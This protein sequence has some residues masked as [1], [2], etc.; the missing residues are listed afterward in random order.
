MSS[1]RGDIA[2]RSAWSVRATDERATSAPMRAAICL[3]LGQAIDY[4]TLFKNLM[5]ARQGAYT[6]PA[7]R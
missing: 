1:V 4:L 7:P 5:A 3:D 6:K 2:R